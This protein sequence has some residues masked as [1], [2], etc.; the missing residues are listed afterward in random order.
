MEPSNAMGDDN[1]PAPTPPPSTVDGSGKPDPLATLPDSRPRRRP[2][3][4]GRG[5]VPASATTI[6]ARVA[7]VQRQLIEG[8]TRAVV[9]QATAKAQREEA[10]A[11]AK[12]LAEGA[13]PDTVSALVPF[14]WGDAPIPDRTLDLYIR[15]AKIK[16]ADDG[17][18]VTRAKEFVLGV[19]LQRL[20]DLYC[21]AVEA[22]RYAVALSVVQ[23]I[24]RMFGLYEAV[25][26]LITNLMQA[27]GAAAGANLG[28]AEGRAEAFGR[29]ARLAVEKDPGLGPLFQR[30]SAAHVHRGTTTPADA[31]A[32]ARELSGQ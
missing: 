31:D 4:A 27:D 22:K 30:L 1:A 29:I 16:T 26:V 5:I 3:A 23:E 20:N 15:K 11:R 32:L 10:A 14:V 7:T 24:N 25:K 21:L 28:T 6:H 13:T 2:P 9:I 12:A 19:Q 18:T 8:R 17:R